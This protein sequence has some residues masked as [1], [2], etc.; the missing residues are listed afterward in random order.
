MVLVLS[1]RS[2]SSQCHC[3]FEVKVTLESNGNVFQFL[4][5]SG[6]LDF[7]RILILLVMIQAFVELCDCDETIHPAHVSTGGSRANTKYVQTYFDIV[8]GRSFS[9]SSMC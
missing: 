1:L 2:R 9:L 8:E 6:R 4:S 7:V 3:H 5:R